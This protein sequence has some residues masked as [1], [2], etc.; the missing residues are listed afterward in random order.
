[1]RPL[2]EDRKFGT[3][4]I[5]VRYLEEMQGRMQNIYVL[6]SRSVGW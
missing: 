4:N 3:Q 2:S 1:M 6:L 5:S